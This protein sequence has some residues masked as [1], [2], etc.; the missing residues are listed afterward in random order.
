MNNE[1]PI[2]IY[3]MCAVLFALCVAY[4]K[5]KSIR[6]I[7]EFLRNHENLHCEWAAYSQGRRNSRR[8][9]PHAKRTALTIWSIRRSSNLFVSE[10]EIEAERE[11]EMKLRFSCRFS[12][13][14]CCVPR[15]RGIQ[16]RKKILNEKLEPSPTSSYKYS[17]SSRIKLE[18]FLRMMC[19][20]F[21]TN[22]V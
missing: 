6:T 18:V 20:Y 15:T 12:W 8:L 5:K 3:I 19:R 14:R 1:I 2:K 21:N 7:E 22:C 17:R 4:K 11:D 16:F 10:G 13:H 9:L